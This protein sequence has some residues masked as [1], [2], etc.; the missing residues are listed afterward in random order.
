MIAFLFLDLC[1]AGNTVCNCS[2][3]EKSNVKKLNYKTLD[4]YVLYDIECEEDNECIFNFMVGVCSKDFQSVFSNTPVAKEFLFAIFSKN[5]YSFT[6][7]NG[8]MKSKLFIPLIPL[9]DALI[10]TNR[11]D[12]FGGNVLGLLTVYDKT[13]LTESR[14]QFDHESRELCYGNKYYSFLLQNK[15]ELYNDTIDVVFQSCHNIL[16]TL[17][18]HNKLNIEKLKQKWDLYNKNSDLLDPV[19][20]A[21]RIF[22]RYAVS[23]K[24]H[25]MLKVKYMLALIGEI[26]CGNVKFY[27]RRLK[28]NYFYLFDK[29]FTKL[30]VTT[31]QDK[32]ILN[33]INKVTKNIS[34]KYRRIKLFNRGLI[35]DDLFGKINRY[36]NITCPDSFTTIADQL[37]SIK[38]D[39]KYTKMM[40]KAELY[41]SFC[42][43]LELEKFEGF[44]FLMTCADMMY[45]HFYLSELKKSRCSSYCFMY[46]KLIEYEP[47]KFE[48]LINLAYETPSDI[49]KN[50]INIQL[51]DIDVS[52]YPQL[53]DY[54][55]ELEAIRSSIL[56]NSIVGGVSICDFSNNFISFTINLIEKNMNFNNDKKINLLKWVNSK[57]FYNG[58]SVSITNLVDCNENPVLKYLYTSDQ[59]SSDSV[60]EDE[61]DAVTNCLI[62]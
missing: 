37:K 62:L 60:S 44:D 14:N 34:K 11:A 8:K 51:K 27:R 6:E 46:D 13:L 10:L 30:D 1:I 36:V 17:K 18:C 31:Q 33:A 61:E 43:Y 25:L 39:P 49:P 3:D 48:A 50:I 22:L 32:H 55:R 59:F 9:Q 53:I 4:K 15:D 23:P 28:S 16:N 21:L 19:K 20:S 26:Q 56:I 24:Y 29:F 54:H 52:K 7:I 40:R 47:L 42:L 45:T 2:S 38:C 5:S 35:S 12:L 57:E 58:I 41:T